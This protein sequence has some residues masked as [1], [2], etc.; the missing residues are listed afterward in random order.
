MYGPCFIEWQVDIYE[1]RNLG[2]CL[3]YIKIK[4]TA[5][6]LKRLRKIMECFSWEK[7]DL[8]QFRIGFFPKGD[9]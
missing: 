3:L 4:C 2:T 6:C 7:Q 1:V 8:S 9:Y 5:I